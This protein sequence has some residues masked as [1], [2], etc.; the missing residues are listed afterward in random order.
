VCTATWKTGRKLKSYEG[1]MNESSQ[2]ERERE[3]KREQTASISNYY[4]A[5]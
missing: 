4:L 3:S 2:R 1:E 5:K